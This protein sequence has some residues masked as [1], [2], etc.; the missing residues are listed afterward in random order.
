VTYAVSA[1]LIHFRNGS[2]ATPRSFA[3]WLTD[4]S[5]LFASRTALALNPDVYQLLDFGIQTS[6]PGILHL[7]GLGC[8][9]KRLLRT[10]DEPG[11]CSIAVLV[12]GPEYQA[13]AV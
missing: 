5:P 2:S 11:V 6:S 1:A 12:R 7:P 10:F 8:P 3:V 13:A 4:A 9:S